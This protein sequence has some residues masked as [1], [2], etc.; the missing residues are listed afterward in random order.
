M[1]NGIVIETPCILCGTIV[2]RNGVPQRNHLEL[3]HRFSPGE[4]A[5]VCDLCRVERTGEVIELTNEAGNWD[6]LKKIW[7]E[8]LTD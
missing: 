4:K 5:C 1:K 2:R 8:G 6:Y 3:E 7:C